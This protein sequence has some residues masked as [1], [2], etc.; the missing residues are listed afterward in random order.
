MPGRSPRTCRESTP[1]G[2]P[3]VTSVDSRCCDCR[4]ARRDRRR[5]QRAHRA[6]C[7]CRVRGGLD[8]SLPR[9]GLVRGPPAL[10]CRG[11]GR[12]RRL[13]LGRRRAR[14]PGRQHRPRRWQRAAWPGDRRPLLARPHP[15]RS[16][17][18]PRRAGDRRCGGDD[19]GVAAAR[20]RRRARL[21]RGL[22]ARASA[23]VG[24]AVATNAG[25]SR[26]VRHG[27]MRAQVMGVEAVLADGSIIGD[28]RGLPKETVGPHLPSLLC[29]SEGTLA[30]ITAARL[31]LVPLLTADRGGDGGARLARRGTGVA[32]R[33]AH[34]G[35]PGRCGARPPGRGGTGRRG[36]RRDLAAGAS[37]SGAAPCSSTA[38]PAQRPDRFA[39]HRGGRARRRA[40]HG[41]AARPPVRRARSHLHLD[42]RSWRAAQARRRRPGRAARARS[43]S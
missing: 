10:H 8:R 28:L 1:S 12:R 21:R 26:V 40:R 30:V 6:G 25:G 7:P 27:T 33:V 3:P 39:R 31:R 15:P 11:R 16:R 32:R 37:P 18:R 29:G 20:P 43:S 38:P 9:I 24:G 22:G 4:R 23:T 34:A 13:R 41:R 14:A 5:V 35:G 17:R 19:R 36:H 42:Q 2:P